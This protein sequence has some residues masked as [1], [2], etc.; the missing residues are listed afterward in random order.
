[1]GTLTR[2]GDPARLM[3]L[4]WNPPA[5]EGR[6]G[7]SVTAITAA[8]VSLADAQGLPALTMRRV[9]EQLSTGTM[10][11]YTHVP[12]KPE[13]IE[14]MIDSVAGRVYADSALPESQGDWRGGL[15][16][17]ADR[18]WRS[19]LAH[20]WTV[21]VVPGRPVLGPGVTGK[22]EA[23]LGALEG[24][25]LSDVEMDLALGVLLGMVEAAA[26]WQIGLDRVRAESGVGDERWWEQVAPLLAQAIS[27]RDYPLGTRVG[28][29]SSQHYHAAGDPTLQLR[30]GVQ[31][32]SDGIEQML[33]R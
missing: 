6:A 23:E 15:T 20:P 25:G 14:L 11:L 30:F 13:L 1:M 22:Y 3:T 24:I 4:L 33:A 31:R 29:A 9:A 8:A 16:W 18:N 26:R 10:S 5:R 28:T 2:V 19:H 21:E 27:D 7:L 32:L 12:G 17:I